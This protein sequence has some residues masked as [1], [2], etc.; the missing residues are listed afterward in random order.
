MNKHPFDGVWLGTFT[1]V[2]GCPVKSGTKT[3]LIQDSKLQHP[4][5]PVSAEGEVT[6]VA[7]SRAIP[8]V[9]VRHRLKLARNAGTGSYQT[10]GGPC[11]GRWALQRA[12][13]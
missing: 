10:I 12:A 5:A 8:N 9:K 11:V 7:P 6:F 13:K 3:F 4:V 1:A 2:Q